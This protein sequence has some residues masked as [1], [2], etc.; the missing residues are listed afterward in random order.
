M[1][2]I[3]DKSGPAYMKTENRVLTIYG[4]NQPCLPEQVNPSPLYPE[5][6]AQL[7]DPSVLRQVALL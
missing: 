2:S 4:Q 1:A 5:L 6:H 3:E 7:K